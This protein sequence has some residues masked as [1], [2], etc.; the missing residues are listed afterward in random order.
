[1]VDFKGPCTRK[2]YPGVPEYLRRDY[3][4]ANVYTIRVHGPVG[5]R[6]G[7]AKPSESPSAGRAAQTEP[8]GVRFRVPAS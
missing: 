3:I 4:K 5:C 1:M 6:E 2:L 7:S 8:K